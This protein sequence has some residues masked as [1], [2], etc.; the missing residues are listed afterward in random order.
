MSPHE[1][2]RRVRV[3]G[4][5]IRHAVFKIFLVWC[6]FDDR[7]D[8]RVEVRER[9]A[10]ACDSDSFDHLYDGSVVGVTW[11]YVSMMCM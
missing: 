4:H 7:E 6:V 11:T 8:K 3:L 2:P 9:G 5:R 10:C 1:H